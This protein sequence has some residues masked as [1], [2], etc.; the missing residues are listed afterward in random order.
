M[1]RLITQ[2]RRGTAEEWTNSGII[3]KPGELVIETSDSNTSKLK[4]GDGETSFTDLPDITADV[5]KR[6]DNIIAGNLEGELVNGLE[7][8]EDY[9][10]YLKSGD[11]RIGDPVIIKG[12][13]G[14]SGIKVKL[15]AIGDTEIFAAK[16]SSVSLQ[17]AFSSTEDGEPT[18][19]FMCSLSV[20][21][22]L[23]ASFNFKQDR[24]IYT[25][26][27]IEKYL[28][29]GTN[30]VVITC[31]D[32]FGTSRSIQYT[33]TIIDLTLSSTFSDDRVYDLAATNDSGSL[34]YEDG[35]QFWYRCMAKADTTVIFTLDGSELA[36][37]SSSA[38]DY[39]ANKLFMLDT[40]DSIKF[41]AGS[42]RL[43]AQAYTQLNETFLY[44]NVLIYDL[45]IQRDMNTLP[46]ISSVLTISQLQE[47]NSLTIPYLVYDPA[48]DICK[49]D[50]AIYS[51]DDHGDWIR[52]RDPVS[53]NVRA[54]L[55]RW[56]IKSYP[57][58]KNVRFEIRYAPARLD[59]PIIVHHE[60]TI[61]PADISVI[62]VSGASLYLTSQD[63]TNA[64]LEG[65]DKWQSGKISTTFSE[66]NWESN[67]WI[68]DT[69]GDICLRINGGAKAIINYAPF[70][71]LDLSVSGLT[72]EID[73]AVH[74]VNRRDLTIIKCSD[75]VDGTLRGLTVT[76]DLIKVSG[77]QDS[78]ECNYK[79]NEHVKLAFTIDTDKD[80]KENPRNNS[81]R[82]LSLY[83]NGTLSSIVRYTNSKFNHGGYIELGDA[84]CT[85]DIYSIRIYPNCLDAK[86]VVNNYIADIPTAAL[87]AQKF[88]DNNI[89][90]DNDSLSFSAISAKIPTITFTGSMPTYKGDKKIVR[91]DFINPLDPDRSFSKVY[92]NDPDYIPALG[93][94]QVEID[95]QGTSS[96]WYVR[97]N[98]KI[99]WKKKKDDVTIFDHAAYQ[100]MPEE[101]P[102]KV[103][104]IKVDYAEA[105]GTHNTQNANFVE[106]L[107]DTQVPAQV[108]NPEVRTTI[109]GFPCVI[110][111][112]A[113]ATD[114]PIFSSKGNFN[115][116]KDSEDAFGFNSNMNEKY[117]VECWEFCNNT[118]D[119]CNFLGSVPA[120]WIDDF[121]PRYTPYSD[122]WDELDEL[123]E[124]RD[125]S[126]DKDGN[127]DPTKFTPEDQAR[128]D[129]LYALLIANFKQMHQWVVST[130]NNVA[131][132]KE[133]FS[134]Y[135]DLE[136]CL[137]YYI[138]T[139]FALMTDQRAKNMFLTRW[140]NK[141][142][143]Y[144]YD[145]DTCFGINN[146]GYRV[147]DYYH[148]DTDKYTKIDNSGNSS[149]VDVY[150]GQKSILWNNF[151]EA[152]S[153]EIKRAYQQ[154]RSS[155]KL[156]YDK[157]I[158]Q[159][160]TQGSDKWS[161]SIYNE[162]AE[163]KYVSMARPENASID[164]ST[165]QLKIDTA[166]LYQVHGNGELHLK[167]FL[168]NRFK[169][170]DSKWD[171]GSYLN[172]FILLRINTPT[173]EQQPS[174]EDIPTN[175]TLTAGETYSFYLV[176]TP[177]AECAL[178]VNDVFSTNI[179]L[180]SEGIYLYTYLSESDGAYTFTCPED[181]ALKVPTAGGANQTISAVPPNPAIELV[182][183]STMYASVRYKANGTPIKKNV[184]ANTSAIFGSDITEV[185]NDTETAIFGASEISELR[186]LSALY[187]SVINTSAASKLSKL[188]IGNSTPGYNNTLLHEV[189][190]GSNAL[191]SEI[192]LT[193]CSGLTKSLD[194]SGCPNIKKVLA[195]GTCISGLS[196]ANAG[197]LSELYLPQTVTALSLKNQ[198]DIELK[199]IHIDGMDT[200][201][202][203]LVSLEIINCG[204]L[205]VKALLDK[206]LNPD[207][208]LSRIELGG[209][210][211]DNVSVEYLQKLYTPRAEGGYGL[212]GLSSDAITISGICTLHENVSGEDMAE[213]REHIKGLKFVLAPGYVISSKVYFMSDDGSRILY[214]EV[215]ETD[216]TEGIN[217]SYSASAPTP[218]R[219]KDN[220]YTY[221]FNGEWSLNPAADRLPAEDALRDILGDR[222][223]YPCFDAIV[224]TYVIT[225][226]IGVSTLYSKS[227]P[228][229]DANGK[230]IIPEFDAALVTDKS[231]LDGNLPKNVVSKNPECYTFKSWYP[232]L[233]PV[234]NNQEY[235]AVFDVT[236]Y[237]TFTLSDIEYSIS[238]TSNNLV[239]KKYIGT[240][241][242]IQIPETL[243]VN[244]KAYTVVSANSSQTEAVGFSH[245]EIEA[246]KIPKTFNP[247]L[248]SF[249]FH[250]A[251]ALSQVELSSE[252]T[253]IP[254]Q[255]FYNCNL[256]VVNIPANVTS[257]G[258]YA[259]GSNKNLTQATINAS[260]KI[261]IDSRA[262][263]SCSSLKEI[264]VN[265]IKT[266]N[267]GAPW[268]AP[269]TTKVLYRGEW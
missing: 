69:N 189:N 184:K 83:L 245:S 86:S 188:V 138:Y 266:Q 105:T 12:G 45:L 109:T 5:N 243:S 27:N 265:W 253:K 80:D 155:G 17:F 112:R 152:F 98:W 164:P 56:I 205:D 224:N 258:I 199:N 118:S 140:G 122:E 47:G 219:P 9:K 193:N 251:D 142:Y 158:D 247:E 172:D 71:S 182:P 81:T 67:G 143:P 242:V 216:S 173:A 139:F 66:F 181:V 227:Y 206:C 19:N 133:E 137:I 116:D 177:N 200:Q 191:L 130:Q 14:D 106:T 263:D 123:I 35:I 42:H 231:L 256:K 186:D 93:G 28:I 85:L 68:Q 40:S 125:D 55:Q 268:G 79:E 151:R 250:S 153:L 259:F 190:L 84:S 261:N 228:A 63:R 117:G 197:Y 170:C 267:D 234:L 21:S 241:Q 154:L 127:I 104:C 145:N 10:L 196:L 3:P 97:K 238:A 269:L 236:S 132:F 187:C 248:V 34:L 101:I 128:L 87:K 77:P 53:V 41:S 195:S 24:D 148:E 119:A 100:H 225:F 147:F 262:F 73:F 134:K 4:I 29:S 13:A 159:F 136:Y 48:E 124:K 244:E 149:S 162:D 20:D 96:Q 169:Y 102:A 202:N 113:T 70:S 166:N 237:Y 209:V 246:I 185:F 90:L 46:M 50:L 213:I 221:T 214:T 192:D 94:M 207:S 179:T 37:V 210:N 76:P 107:Y 146:E 150:N 144:F 62:P 26:D 22:L 91:M 174:I 183:F 157:L 16:N 8:T 65:R 39:A 51:Q 235:E 212:K 15:S 232:D 120:A 178:Y 201:I 217:C 171:A 240:N 95:V 108:D 110:F 257:I 78:V 204:N 239:I 167:Y 74:D 161:A 222:K 49:V 6:I 36:Q 208:H 264:R 160:I 60:L 23:K 75:I 99:K 129:A 58:A 180:N 72:F 38:A 64:D 59:D 114:T 2:Q 43:T 229:I 175:I 163:Y 103:F 7:Y 126:K 198:T 141:W 230:P 255:A 11:K 226:K 115:F 111:E 61:L 57:V 218:L 176:G 54:E 254:S 165:Q 156:A 18:G 25:I 30:A 92:A 203:N 52:Y 31:T 44:S 220:I 135:F 233:S 215:L 260:N 88:A 1:K 33:I 168:E 121:E 82:F 223:V 252:T 194:L 249:I 89:Y 211:W 131:K 32:A